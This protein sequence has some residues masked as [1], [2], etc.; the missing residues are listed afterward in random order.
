MFGHAITIDNPLHNLF[1]NAYFCTHFSYLISYDFSKAFTWVQVAG[2]AWE[3]NKL[4]FFTAKQ[5]NYVGMLVSSMWC[6]RANNNGFAL[7]KNPTENPTENPAENKA[8][9]DREK[10]HLFRGWK[11]NHISIMTK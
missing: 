4:I 1:V 8:G 3:H 6:R 11:D 2:P 7:D 9:Y 10:C 5:E